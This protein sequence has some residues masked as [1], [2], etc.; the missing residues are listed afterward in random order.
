MIIITVDTSSWLNHSHKWG[1]KG[2]EFGLYPEE[3]GILVVKTCQNY[4]E[5]RSLQKADIHNWGDHL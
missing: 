5:L 1:P 2:R 4:R 3:P